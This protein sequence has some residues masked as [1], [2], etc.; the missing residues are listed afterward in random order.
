MSPV[1]GGIRSLTSR[2]ALRTHMLRF[3]RSAVSSCAALLTAVP[4]A[5]QTP[6]TIDFAEFRSPTTEVY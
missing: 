5:G 1:L 6:V 4:L 2:P 3:S